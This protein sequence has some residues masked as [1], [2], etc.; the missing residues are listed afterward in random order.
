M[1]IV[2]AISAAK[3]TGKAVRS[4]VWP[5]EVCLVE[6]SSGRLRVY[7]SRTGTTAPHALTARE[8]MSKHWELSEVRSF[9]I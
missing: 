8:V 3:A 5:K 9:E 4:K 1:N 7:D 6:D 2:D